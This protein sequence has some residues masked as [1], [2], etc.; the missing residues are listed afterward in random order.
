SA[1]RNRQRGERRRILGELVDLAGGEQDGE[2]THPAAGQVMRPHEATV[3]VASPEPE[4]PWLS[5]TVTPR[6]SLPGT[7]YV[8]DALIEPWLGVQLLADPLPQ[9]ML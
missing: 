8:C 2:Q 4:R 7:T 5:V 3:S 9:S 1:R 6:R